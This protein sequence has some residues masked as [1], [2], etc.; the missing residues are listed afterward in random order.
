MQVRRSKELAVWQAKSIG[1]NGSTCSP[2]VE[3]MSARPGIED[4]CPCMIM[5][6][7]FRAYQK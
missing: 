2:G 7:C 3:G 1:G 5:S 6:S 4:D